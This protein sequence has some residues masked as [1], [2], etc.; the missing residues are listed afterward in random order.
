MRPRLAVLLAC[1]VLLSACSKEPPAPRP[2]EVVVYVALDEEF[3]RPLLEEYEREK[4]VKVKAAFDQETAKSTVLSTRLREEADRPQADVWW[5][6]EPVLARLLAQEGLLE[7]YESPSARDIPSEFVDADHRFVSFAARARVIVAN[8]QLVAE[9]ETPRSI[10]DLTKPRWKGKVGIAKPIFGTTLTHTASLFEALGEEKAKEWLRA[11][12]ANDVRILPGNGAV[13]DQVAAGELDVGLTDTDDANGAVVDGKPV[14]VV[15]PDADGLGTLVMP[16]T[17]AL[18]K[19]APR[20]AE[21]RA[22]IDWVLRPE[23]EARL[24]ASRSSQMPVRPSVKVPEGF[25]GLSSIK[26][27]PVDF[28]KAAARLPDVFQFLEAEFLR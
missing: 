21:G 24:A 2:R 13:R 3:A 17:I 11:L 15:Y 20:A 9:E 4:G 18:V 6:N 19:G 8:T 25:V 7:A 22:F 27:M 26:A 14:R 12:K 1:L 28:D 16:N 5:N 10:W 23:V